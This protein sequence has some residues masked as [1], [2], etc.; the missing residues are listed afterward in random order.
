M[1]R[2]GMTHHTRLATYLWPTRKRPD[3]NLRD[4][5]LFRFPFALVHDSQ[6]TAQL[7]ISQK[8]LIFGALNVLYS[9]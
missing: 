9:L 8:D 3:L 7:V 2:K 4:T 6:T 1:A 5:P